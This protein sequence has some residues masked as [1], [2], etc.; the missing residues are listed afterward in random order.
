MGILISMCITT[1]VR[2]IYSCWKRGE[3]LNGFDSQK[4]FLK[5]QTEKLLCVLWE[6]KI[7]SFLRRKDC[8]CPVVSRS[9]PICLGQC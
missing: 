7:E 8:V 2:H 9:H 4:A 3:E 6:V 1:A 5:A